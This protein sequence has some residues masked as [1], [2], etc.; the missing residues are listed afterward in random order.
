MENWRPQYGEKNTKLLS[1][2]QE[3]LKSSDGFINLELQISKFFKRIF[4]MIYFSTGKLR[5]E[6]HYSI[7]DLFSFST[8]D[9]FLN[10]KTT[11]A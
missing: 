2:F 7:R 1:Y 6:K 3:S 11:C 4:V 10:Y 9:Y 8:N 5:K